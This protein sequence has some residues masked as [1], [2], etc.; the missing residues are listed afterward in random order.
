MSRKVGGV[1]RS[2]ADYVSRI[3]EKVWPRKTVAWRR[4]YVVTAV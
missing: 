2:H 4:R 1:G 3:D